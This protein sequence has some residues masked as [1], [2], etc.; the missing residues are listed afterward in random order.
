MINFERPVFSNPTRLSLSATKVGPQ[1]G[2]PGACW[3]RG[4]LCLRLGRQIMMSS[5]RRKLHRR[6][7]MD[8]PIWAAMHHSGM[9]T[10]GDGGR[11]G[12]GNSI[13]E[14]FL[15]GW[16][17]FTNEKRRYDIHMFSDMM[18]C[19]ASSLGKKS[20]TKSAL[21]IITYLPSD[22]YM[23]QWTGSELPEPMLIHYWLDPWEQTFTKSES[24]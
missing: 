14:L 21:N 5:R 6:P 1:Q 19:I 16:G 10:D 23:R 2:H 15:F 4:P 13:T 12:V 17:F 20:V 18:P 22:V 8:T 7:W 3:G 24:K 11:D 9:T